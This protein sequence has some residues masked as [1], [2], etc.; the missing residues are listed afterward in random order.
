[1]NLAQ[2]AS[3]ES[4]LKTRGDRRTFVAALFDEKHSNSFV[5]FLA[6]QGEGGSLG[7]ALAGIGADV[8]LADRCSGYASALVA[9]E[10]LF[11]AAALPGIEWMHVAEPLLPFPIEGDAVHSPRIA[12]PRVA[13]ELKP[14]DPFFDDASIRLDVLRRSDSNSD[15]RGS[16]IAITDDGVDWLH[17]AF[18]WALDAEGGEVRKIVDLVPP[19]VQSE[20]YHWVRCEAVAERDGTIEALG[21]IWRAPRGGNY[22]LGFL[23]MKTVAILDPTIGPPAMILEAGVLWDRRTDTVRV[24]I[25][26]DADFSDD[27]PLR[28]YP[29]AGE[30]GWFGAIDGD[31]DDRIPFGIV[32][33]QEKSAVYIG[34]PGFHGSLVAGSAAASTR[35]G[36]LYDGVAPA[37]QLIS[38]PMFRK[39]GSLVLACRDPR[40][41]VVNRSGRTGGE[42]KD[43]DEDFDGAV[44]TRLIETYDVP[45]ALYGSPPGSIFVLDYWTGESLERNRRTSPPYLEGINAQVMFR[46][47]GEVNVVLAPST[48]LMVECRYAP[49]A[50]PGEDGIRRMSPTFLCPPAPDGYGVAANP[51]PT[52]PVV[53][54]AIAVLS[55]L[56]RRNGIRYNARRMTLAI[57]G[58][59]RHLPDF[60]IM[61]Q[62]RGLLDIP[63]AW[64]LLRGAARADDPHE[65]T[66]V[67]FDCLSGSGFAEDDPPLNGTRTILVARRGGALGGQKYRLE[68][69]GDLDAFKLLD[70]RIT[71]ARDAATP[72]RFDFLPVAG[73]KIAFLRIVDE[74]ADALVAEIPLSVRRPEPVEVDEHGCTRFRTEIP[75]RRAIRRLLRVEEGLDG[76][77]VTL[78]EGATGGSEFANAA[79]FALSDLDYARLSFETTE[80]ENLR[81]AVAEIGSPA[82]GI[83][84]IFAEN[85]SRG[86]YESPH[87]SPAPTQP[88]PF[89]FHLEPYRVDLVLANGRLGLHNRGCSFT[90]KVLFFD[91]LTTELTIDGDREK[92]SIEVEVPGD[93]AEWRID[94]SGDGL[95]AHVIDLSGEATAVRADAEFRGSAA[96]LVVRSPS[97]GKWIIGVLGASGRMNVRSTFLT[98]FASEGESQTIRTGE[99]DMWTLPDRDGEPRYAAIEVD[100]VRDR[101]PFRL[102]TKLIDPRAHDR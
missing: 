82:G 25:G 22:E 13:R 16:V 60:P 94:V 21:K 14:D 83:A 40:V 58:S 99:A 30:I 73:H 38:F 23:R 97:A 98:A 29:I 24:D 92:A 37:A 2:R 12:Y 54:G 65:A 90:G 101:A 63:A 43:G 6:G 47:D 67:S 18:A 68:L 53:S 66:L 74:A 5:E 95:S 76:V 72:I 26:G 3:L 48:N 41:D 88:I 28:P 42:S 71:A 51:S 78:R 100:A 10:K 50:Y 102:P 44:A 56:A 79:T 17:P 62:G 11:D 31:R 35:G 59:A 52:I 19:P 15:G 7:V 86:E 32:L 49:A 61:R 33:D 45:I 87:D 46:P 96:S 57:M 75:P 34:V 69:R 64:D 55:S 39:L 81:E 4:I 20:D 91:A 70:K 8:V 77:R 93:L 1:M 85:R 36:G 9:R 27:D 80:D 89:E 84:T